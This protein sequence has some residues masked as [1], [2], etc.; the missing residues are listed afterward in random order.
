M[1]ANISPKSKALK[2]VKLARA[3]LEQAVKDFEDGADCI[4]VMKQLNKSID[5]LRL[6]DGMIL[7]KH[8][9]ECLPKLKS[10]SLTEEI[11][12]TFKCSR[13]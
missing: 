8:L 7:D 12:K 2:Q 4:E 13:R 10:D 1:T 3:Q 6:A 9:K 5:H 11:V